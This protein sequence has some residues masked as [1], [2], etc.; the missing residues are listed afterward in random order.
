MP[1]ICT[2]EEIDYLFSKIQNALPTVLDP[3]VVPEEMGVALS[4]IMPV[5]K[6]ER[7]KLLQKMLDFSSLPPEA[8]L[9]E[10]IRVGYNCTK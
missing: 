4:T 9:R 5:I 10:T 8:A 6:E 3:Y 1:I 7:P 2:D